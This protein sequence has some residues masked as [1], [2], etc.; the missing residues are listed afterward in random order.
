MTPGV[1]FVTVSELRLRA[2]QIVGEIERSKNQIVVTK[3]GRPV[4]VISPAREDDF[5][6]EE[7]PKKKTK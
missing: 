1:K 2:T 7:K 5:S 4:V 3:N 6:Y